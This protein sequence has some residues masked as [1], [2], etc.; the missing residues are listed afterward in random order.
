MKHL[1]PA[2]Y[3]ILL[4][5]VTLPA[6]LVAQRKPETTNRVNDS[7]Y[8]F[9]SRPGYWLG[10]GDQ[11]RRAV[12]LLAKSAPAHGLKSEDYLF[13]S[14]AGNDKQFTAVTISFL[15]HL[16]RGNVGK[17]ISY[18]EV[19]HAFTGKTDSVVLSVLARSQN[20]PELL[21]LLT[22]QDS[23]YRLLSQQLL[24]FAE[25]PAND[26]TARLA[27]ATN[28]YRWIKHYGFEKYIVVNIPSA[29]LHLYDHD[30]VQLQMKVVVGKPS[31]RTPRFSSWLDKVIL[32]PYWNVPASIAGK[33]LL[34][35][36][37][38]SPAKVAAMNMQILD[39][40]GRILDPN[41]L[42]WQSFHRGNFPYTIRQCTGCDN[43]LG[44][45]KF[46]LTDP[47]SVYMH[48]T[49]NKPAFM[50]DYRYLSHGCIRLS[51]PVSLGN[52]L[53]DNK[54]DTAFLA[55][56]FKNEKPQELKLERLVPV[57]VIYSTAV[58]NNGEISY[59][60]DIYH[61]VR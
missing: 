14:P 13:P 54:L 34:P 32:Y 36:F 38:R 20:D 47:F 56:C 16:Y 3:I 51:D 27:A 37:K 40:S 58:V 21:H 29:T 35:V 61:L 10:A 1:P 17:L 7:L 28:L 19:E 26:T 45:L 11:L 30:T 9:F 2:L 41:T 15:T 55:A 5:S 12:L 8:A 43:A 25:K 60:K 6:R 31:T 42:N 49:N 39:K 53:L 18:D 50:S 57:F 23:N 4:F 44:V 46:N 52:A 24:H 59:Y 33:E 22:P 48:D